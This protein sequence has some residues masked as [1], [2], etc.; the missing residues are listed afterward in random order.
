MAI[1]SPLIFKEMGTF[2]KVGE[3]PF[4][5]LDFKENSYIIAGGEKRKIALR[6]PILMNSKSF[7]NVLIWPITIYVEGLGQPSSCL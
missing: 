7:S 2:K 3:F 1:F 4:L 6:F 5:M